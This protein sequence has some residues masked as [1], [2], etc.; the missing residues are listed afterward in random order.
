MVG[1]WFRA[2][3]DGYWYKIGGYTSTSVLTLE[4]KYDGTTNGT[5]AFT[6]GDSPEI[7]EDG[8]ELL[9]YRA[10]EMYYAGFRKDSGQVMFWGNMFWTGDGNNSSR[11]PGDAAGGLLNL[12]TRYAKRSDSRIIHRRGNIGYDPYDKIFGTTITP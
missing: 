6:I 9:A 12:I 10:T 11:E 1:Q 2:T 7:P 4:M 5:A 3:T 8:H